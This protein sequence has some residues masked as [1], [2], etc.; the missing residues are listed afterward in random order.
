MILGVQRLL[1]L[2]I[3]TVF[4]RAEQP[5]ALA[6]DNGQDI[7]D[8]FLHPG[9]IG[10]KAQPT[11]L[12][13]NDRLARVVNLIALVIRVRR[14]VISAIVVLHEESALP[15]FLVAAGAH[16]INGRVERFPCQHL[17]ARIAA[18]LVDALGVRSP[19][20]G[21]YLHPVA[22][23]AMPPLAL[24]LRL[25]VYLDVGPRPED[26]ERL[27]QRL[28]EWFRIERL[29][30]QFADAHHGHDANGCASLCGTARL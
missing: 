23:P 14:R 16:S 6:A 8:A 24:I 13:L 19:V 10:Q 22:R 11:Q 2:G 5:A 20:A 25:V 1:D 3:A 9:R 27:T 29:I 28:D 18:G 4:F 7:A 26:L 12:V 21:E 30:D 15:E 17:D